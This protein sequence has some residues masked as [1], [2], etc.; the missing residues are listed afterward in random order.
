MY[1]TRYRNH[2]VTS[3]AVSADIKPIY[4]YS[5]TFLTLLIF[6]KYR[7]VPKSVKTVETHLKQGKYEI[8]SVDQ[9][10]VTES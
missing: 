2:A 5:M 4:I 9:I 1:C 6:G 8:L 10:E 3:S 7:D